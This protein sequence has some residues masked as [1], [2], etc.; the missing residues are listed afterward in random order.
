MEGS[1]TPVEK[2]RWGQADLTPLKV[3]MGIVACFKRKRAFTPMET[4]ISF[5]S[6]E[7]HI[8]NSSISTCNH[9]YKGNNYLTIYLESS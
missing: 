3:I 1:R 7:A 4:G 8:H 5:L 2:K 9:G 6:I